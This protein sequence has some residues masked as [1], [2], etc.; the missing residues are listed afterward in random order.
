[1]STP[2]S[3]DLPDRAQPVT[4][5]TSRGAFAALKAEPAMGV[6]E[7]RPALLIP[8]FTGSK[9]DFIAV[10]QPL[11]SAGRE[12]VAIDMRGQYQSPAAPDNGG[13]AP[14]ELAADI[15]A[16]ARTLAGDGQGLHLVGHSL[17]GL[18]AREAVLARATP[19]ISLTLLSSGP[20]RISGQRAEL[21]RAMLALMAQAD[22]DTRAAGDE[23]RDAAGPGR[24]AAGEREEDPAPPGDGSP[25]DERLRPSVEAIWNEHLEPQA[26]ADGVPEGMIGFLRERMLGNSPAGLVAMG[27][28][29]LACPDRT[30]ELANLGGP[31]IMVLYGENDDAWRPAAQERMA[32]RLSAS[33]VCIPG[34]GHSPAVEAPETTA[35][36]LT[37]FWKTAEASERRRGV[38]AAAR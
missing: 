15:G 8:G 29:L 24:D 23:G 34:A 22:L 31:P 1:M 26:V 9:E 18:I 12:V 19:V 5:Q 25:A 27:T 36:T 16:I 3:L 2:R 7:R 11:A 14:G 33:R 13:Y 4:I 20:A 38:S 30:A 6:C 32:R 21:L 10:L 37:A 17:G 28:Y 35:S